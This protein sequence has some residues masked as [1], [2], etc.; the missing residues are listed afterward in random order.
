[1][2]LAGAIERVRSTVRPMLPRA[3]YQSFSEGVDTL[4]GVRRMGWTG[5]RR[6]RATF[7]GH[8]DP[9]SRLTSFTIPPIAHELW[10][11]PGT[12]DGH[13]LVSSL[14]REDYGTFLP[15]GPVK[16]VIDAGGYIGDSAIWYLTRFPYAKV[17]SLEPDPLNFALL[18]RNCVSYGS[19]ATL[20]RAGIWP[21]DSHLKVIHC[22][23]ELTVE[24]QE[25]DAAQEYDVVGMSPL[26]LLEQAGE[27]EIDILKCNIEGA[28]TELFGSDCDAW[29]SCTRSI[30]VQIHHSRAME[31]V[32]SATR[33]HGFSC[34]RHRYLHIF[35]RQ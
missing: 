19:R 16:L 7:R 14:I 17:I 9:E 1:M 27:S 33:R 5:Y 28:E 15:T 2:I 34:R 23:D 31:S 35:H 10:I 8:C 6:L 4:T 22:G 32:M 24:V 20:L 25:V 3:I 30:Y 12:P 18:Q 26:T 29:L 11:R 13:S 21:R